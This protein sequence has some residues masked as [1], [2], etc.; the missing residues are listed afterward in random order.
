MQT[1]F[2]TNE[3]KQNET[4]RT[5]FLEEIVY[6]ASIFIICMALYSIFLVGHVFKALWQT[7][8]SISIIKPD[9]EIG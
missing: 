8:I 5:N 9:L 6:C 1:Y 7:Y 3:T 2:E 4:K